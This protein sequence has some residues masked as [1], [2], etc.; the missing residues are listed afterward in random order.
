MEVPLTTKNL[1]YSPFKER[2]VNNKKK[3]MLLNILITILAICLVALVW[4]IDD[5]GVKITVFLLLLLP[6]G[7]LIFIL[8]ETIYGESEDKGS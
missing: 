4:K 3:N 7:L 6:L 2:R 8:V 5:T 1:I